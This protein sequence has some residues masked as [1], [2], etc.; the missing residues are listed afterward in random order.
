MHKQILITGGLGFIG[1]NLIQKLIKQKI[2]FIIIDNLS[3]ANI[4]F[5]KKL[6]KSRYV[7]IKSDICNLSLIRKKIKNF[8]PELIIHLASL[9]YIPDC[10]KS[11][12]ST[13]KINVKG[14]Q[15]MLYLAKEIKINKFLFSSSAAVYKPGDRRLT[16]KIHLEP[17]DIYGKSKLAAEKEISKFCK[18]ID[19]KFTILRLFNVYGPGDQTPHFIPSILKKIKNNIKIK[20]GNLNT[21]RDYIYI[22]D[23]T[24]IVVKIIND[25]LGFE[26]NI[27]NIG[28]GV[29]TSGINIVE[30]LRKLTSKKI[31]VKLD[32]KLIRRSDRKVL[33]ADNKKISNKYN[34][35]PK[36]NLKLGLKKTI[37]YYL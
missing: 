3:N 21:Y 25:K 27:Y 7:L 8:N 14:T 9:H 20:L 26:N 29:K 33:F 2:F 11:P 22:D 37:K 10:N 18:N 32:S 17:I 24:N 6:P 35:F 12:R 1:C 23:I 16:E 5:L 15:N 30:I 31:I 36:F 4:N 28:T 13:Y 34:W 19:L